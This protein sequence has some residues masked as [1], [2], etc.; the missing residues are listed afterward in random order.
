MRAP[1]G[2]ACGL[3]LFLIVALGGVAASGQ[4][5]ILTFAVSPSPL[6]IAAGGL[7]VVRLRVENPS[8]READDIE[9][10]WRDP[11]GFSLAPAPAPIA[12]LSPF[13]SLAVDIPIAVDANVLA[14][15]RTGVFEVVYTYCIDDYCFQ[16]V[17]DVPVSLII[18]EASQTPSGVVGGQVNL[19]TTTP[20]PSKSKIPW[21]MG[22]LAAAG[23]LILVGG[24]VWRQRG[25]RWPLYTVL[26]V[27]VA[28]SLAYGVSLNQQNQAQGIGAVLCTSCVGIEEAR[29]HEPHLTE[30]QAA[31]IR[32]LETPSELIVFYAPW[33]HACPFAE[34]LVEQVARLND[35]ITYRFVNVEEDPGMASEYG[36][37]RS[38]RTVVPATVRIGVGQVLFGVEDLESRL[39]QLLE[40]TP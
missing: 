30:A 1:A 2:W 26:A 36:V 28:G 23:L 15:P 10:A 12:V 24:V 22:G 27:V 3:C 34:V 17:E 32:A 6:E 40:A 13:Q 37:I 33:C 19:P 25:V 8:I 39:V 9:V 14:G 29:T 18:T 38:G 16:I 20:L 4:E 5:A 31:R 11:A 21:Q 35:R 7:G